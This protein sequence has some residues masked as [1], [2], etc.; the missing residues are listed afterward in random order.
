MNKLDIFD[1]I[2]SI[3]QHDASCCKD[4]PGE[5]AALYRAKIWNDMDDSDFL[6]VVKSYLATFHVAAHVSFFQ[7]NRGTIPFRV[8]RYHDALYVSEA[9]QDSPLSVGDRI[10]EID[11][12]PVADFAAQHSQMLYG[13]PEERQGFCWFQ[14]LSFA[15]EVSAIS[16]AEQ[17]R[18]TCPI[19]LG[20]WNWGAGDRY[21]CKKLR[22]D[23]VYLQFKDFGDEEAIQALYAEN[24]TLLRSCRYLVIDVR[25]NGGGSDT[26]FFPLLEFCLPDGQTLAGLKDGPYDSKMEINYT[27]R[28]C[29]SRMQMI[30]EYKAMDLPAETC[31]LLQ[32]ME[33]ELTANRGK[34]FRISDSSDSPLPF[35]GRSMPKKVYILTDQ[36]C[37]SSGD[38]FVNLMRKSE[39]VTVIGRP[40]MGI[41]DFSNCTS[42]SY[43]A[44]EFMYP[45]SR[46]LY[47]DNGVR[48]RGNGVPVDVYLPWTPEHLTRDIDMAKAM[49]LIDAEG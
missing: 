28:N 48:M 41:L 8:H 1:D 38:A 49:E 47:L 12:L 11:G 37:G 23:V 45:T 10:I 35:V 26:A 9:A 24:D 32:Q 25:S 19:T 4:E 20:Y 39:K 31:T 2:V 17:T 40:T 30:A 29:D 13:E 22:D 43:G 7:T 6:F 27:E 46:A 21:L 5:D 33:A 3:M 16:A 34:G 18:M 42:V 15:H 14:L 36:D 44:F